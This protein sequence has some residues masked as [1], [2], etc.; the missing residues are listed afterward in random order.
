MTAERAMNLE[1]RIKEAFAE[2]MVEVPVGL[3]QVMTNHPGDHHVLAAAVT[4]K[5]DIIVTSNLK[6]FKAKDLA[7]WNIKAQSPDDFLTHLYDLY[8]DTMIEVVRRQCQVLK[9][10][11][12][13]VAEL[14]DLRSYAVEKK[15]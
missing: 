11:P 10:P 14:V 5:A 2:A 12:M 1:T 3:A 7:R 13:T 8:P 4:A 6:H 15:E 9:K